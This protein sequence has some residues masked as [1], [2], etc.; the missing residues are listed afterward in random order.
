MLK[1]AI[2]VFLIIPVF[3]LNSQIPEDDIQV[4][5]LYTF[6]KWYIQ[7]SNSLET[8][9]FMPKVEKGSKG[10]A[11]LG[12]DTYCAILTHSGYFTNRFIESEKT[13][14]KP[15]ADQIAKMKY[16]TY[17]K[18]SMEMG[19]LPNECNCFYYDR[20]FNAQDNP[21]RIRVTGT[22][23]LGENS[24]EATFVFETGDEK[25]VSQWDTKCKAIME[26]ESGSWKIT[27]LEF[28]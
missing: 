20:W 14:L 2:L 17:E 3:Q 6:Y 24:V 10:Y 12:V 4:K 26:L 28:N 27:G 8:T 5:N 13:R 11:L 1:K 16:S 25:N 18:M 22:K 21:D 23:S 19:G 15:C 7:K 9:G